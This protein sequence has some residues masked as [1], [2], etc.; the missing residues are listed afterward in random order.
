[1]TSIARKSIAVTAALKKPTRKIKGAE[2]FEC[3]KTPESPLYLFLSIIFTE[4][5]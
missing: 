1:M 5:C 3:W 4:R 2:N